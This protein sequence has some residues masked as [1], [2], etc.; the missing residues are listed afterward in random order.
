MKIAYMFLCLIFS[1]CRFSSQDTQYN[2][3]IVSVTD[4][5]VV[6][7]NSTDRN[8][9]VPS[10]KGK[11]MPSE[12]LIY[13]CE[14]S[15]LVSIGDNLVVRDDLDTLHPGQSKTYLFDAI[16]T[17]LHETYDDEIIYG[18]NIYDL[19]NFASHAFEVGSTFTQYIS[20][21]DY[22]QD[23]HITML[24]NFRPYEDAQITWT[25]HPCSN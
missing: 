8:Y 23:C 9:L 2:V 12:Y 11:I 10:W 14:E 20:L 19:A 7:S 5:Q 17:E 13:N 21:V 16:A 22:T 25:K 18:V 15:E 1:S 24:G 6:I 3:K 4:C